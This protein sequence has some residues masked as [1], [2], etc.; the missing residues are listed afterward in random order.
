MNQIESARLRRQEIGAIELAESER[1]PAKRIA[2]ADQFAFTH[3]D[4]RERAL[5]PAQRRQYISAI[6]RGLRQEM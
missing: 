3:D 1:A 4:Q 5:D 2:H 6:L